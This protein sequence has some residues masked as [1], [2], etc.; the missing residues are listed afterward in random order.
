MLI[1][2]LYTVKRLSIA[3]TN[4]SKWFQ[5]LLSNTNSSICT[6]LNGFK[7]CYLLFAYSQMIL[8]IAIQH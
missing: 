4:S 1:I 3:N 6:Q 2:C 5:T 8:S 7:Y